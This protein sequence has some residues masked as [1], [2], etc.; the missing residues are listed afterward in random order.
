MTRRQRRFG[1]LI[2]RLFHLVSRDRGI[3]NQHY[4]GMSSDACA[5]PASGTGEVSP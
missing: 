1:G 2:R 4:R 5:A 3:A